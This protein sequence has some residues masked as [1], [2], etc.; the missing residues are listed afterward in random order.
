MAGELGRTKA[1]L[2]SKHGDE[3]GVQ[4]FPN[5]YVRAETHTGCSLWR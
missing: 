4:L 1:E 2:T 5:I 3:Q